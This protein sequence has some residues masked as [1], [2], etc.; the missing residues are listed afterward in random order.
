MSGKPWAAAPWLSFGAAIAAAVLERGYRDDRQ[1]RPAIDIAGDAGLP[2]Q[3]P[4]LDWKSIRTFAERLGD[5]RESY[6]HYLSSDNGVAILQLACALTFVWAGWSRVPRLLSLLLAAAAGLY[7]VG[8]WVASALLSSAI[9][10]SGED[11][12]LFIAAAFATSVK[13]ALLWAVL[14]LAAGQAYQLL[15]PRAWFLSLFHD[16]PFFVD[17][18]LRRVEFRLNREY[19]PADE[20]DKLRLRSC[21]SLPSF[22]FFCVVLVFVCY[23]PTLDG[24]CSVWPAGA[25]GLLLLSAGVLVLVVGVGFRA[26]VVPWVESRVR[27]YHFPVEKK[28]KAEDRALEPNRR[29]I[30]RAALYVC[31]LLLFA[32]VYLAAVAFYVSWTNGICS[33]VAFSWPSLARLLLC[34]L[35]VLLFAVVWSKGGPSNVVLRWQAGILA[36]AAL[37]LWFVLATSDANEASRQPYRHLFGAI[38]PL[39]AAVLL[40]APAIARWRIGK[41]LEDTD[42]ARLLRQREL[43]VEREA[44][45]IPSRWRVT[46]ALFY[47]IA[48]KALQLALIPALLALVAS[49]DLLW[50]MAG[51]GLLLSIGLSTWGSLFLRW[52]QMVVLV[53]RWFLTGAAFF[54]SI[55]VVGMALARVSDVSYVTTILDGAP[56]GVVVVGTLMCYVL[57]W[58]VEY[59]INRAAAVEL[60]RVLGVTGGGT[61]LAYDFEGELSTKVD[62]KGRHLVVHGIGRFLVCGRLPGRR[63]P[64]FH[65]Y[66]LVELFEELDP[67]PDKADAA[68]VGRHLHLYFYALNVLLLAAALAVGAVYWYFYRVSQPA[69]VVTVRADFDPARLTDLAERLLAPAGDTRPALVVVASGGGTRAAVFAAHVLEGLHRIGADRDIVLTSGVSG[70]G[71]ALAYFALHY[72]ELSSSP[73]QESP[74]W[75]DFKKAVAA[76]YIE[77]VIQ[78]ASESRFFGPSP[79]SF[80]L[81]E[82]FDRRLLRD[83]GRPATFDLPDTP[84]LILN[85]TITGHPVEDSALLI[86]TLNRPPPSESCD[87]AQRPF[88]L[89]SG[90]RLIF[91]N[92]KDVS[93]FP[94]RDGPIPDV[95]LPYEIVR[96]P[97][98]RL[99]RAAAL[100]ANFPPVFPNARVLI[101]NQD[102]N[103]P[104]GDRSYLVT[105]GGV[106]ENLG[107]I[108]ALYAVDSA[109][110]EITGRCPK[111]GS[112][113]PW[114]KRRLRAI[115]FVIAE[116]SATGYDYEQDRGISTIWETAK[117]RMT[118]GLTNQL[119]RSVEGRYLRSAMERLDKQLRFRYLAMP[120]V[121]RSR[122]GIGTHW[123]HAEHFIFSDPRVRSVYPSWNVERVFLNWKE[124]TRIWTALHDPNQL[125]CEGK[126]Y[127]YGG[128]NTDTVRRWIC[129][130]MYDGNQPRDLHVLEWRTLVGHLRPAPPTP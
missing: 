28:R 118:G 53:D 129:G 123:T 64:A 111:E 114:C 14:A 57:A 32:P 3:S 63:D 34:V 86:I 9:R 13:W 106:E 11:G 128:V 65:T 102:P 22:W 42:F 69:A 127:S 35:G 55:F 76:N 75:E 48:Y 130:S 25:H 95:R 87:E 120:L 7:A 101:K 19:V 68:T 84:A 1:L 110:R 83:A 90:G 91:T 125:Y 8:N 77:D 97:D 39:A 50:W 37:L 88:R 38:A 119:A 45:P 54:V 5:E 104:C 105:D 36:A 60:L 78:G 124:V 6:L 99:S 41:P 46:H 18:A 29:R 52:Q 40:L 15:Q 2:D 117:D 17:S 66:N 21:W 112:R 33:G 100:N 10:G 98:V 107:L 24:I 122:G 61:A 73:A 27:G 56:Y 85:T 103:T 74:Q 12:E 113:D 82:T 62:A 4:F 72:P 44:A 30:T 79:L 115:H 70:G 20:A 81:A 58:L 51:L 89:M 121:F 59:W 109:L 92:L 96:D 49:P 23:G 80:L 93:G 47:G 31:A 16:I 26:K 94:A 67:K 71:V 116:A 108:S 126:D 43:F